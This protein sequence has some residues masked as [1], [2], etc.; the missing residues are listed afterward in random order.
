[1]CTT[2][3][4]IGDEYFNGSTISGLQTALQKINDGF[5][6][7]PESNQC[8]ELMKSYLCHYY[9]PSCDQ[10]TGKII[11]VCSD[12]CTLT[13]NDKDCVTLREIVNYELGQVN[14]T[15][16]NESCSQTHHPF[17]NPPLVSENCL[18]IEG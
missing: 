4:D 3:Y 14:A 7:V 18:P 13:L 12:N 11:P 15:S 9:F 16:L 10:M 5:L 2:Y 6:N 1:M 17:V 8:L